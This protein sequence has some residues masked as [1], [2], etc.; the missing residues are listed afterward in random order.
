MIKEC[1]MNS[2]VRISD[3][4]DMTSAVYLGRKAINQTN[5]VVVQKFKTQMLFTY[6]VILPH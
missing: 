1:R 2:V 5:K 3:L 4:P 6:D